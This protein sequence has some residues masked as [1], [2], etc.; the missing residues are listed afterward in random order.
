MG[1]L[2]RRIFWGLVI[3]WRGSYANR[4]PIRC[5]SCRLIGFM[6]L[7]HRY[8]CISHYLQCKNP[9]RCGLQWHQLDVPNGRFKGYAMNCA[10]TSKYDRVLTRASQVAG[11]GVS[12]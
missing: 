11:G 1:R 10:D 4:H 7:Y 6:H 9:R 2:L 12:S 8:D 5:P 3:R